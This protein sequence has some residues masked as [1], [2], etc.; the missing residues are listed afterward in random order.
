MQQ[1]RR[2]FIKSFTKAAKAKSILPWADEDSL[3]SSCT[4]CQKCI[5]ACPTG[6]LI[7]NTDTNYP[8]LDFHKSYCDFC[9]KC[10]DICPEDVFDIN[11]QPAIS[12]NINLKKS[13]CL[14]YNDVLCSSCRDA[15]DKNAIKP[16]RQLP[17]PTAPVIDDNCNKCG[18]CV[19]ICPQKAIVIT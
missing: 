19:D 7:S 1:S 6:V 5:E 10:A 18:A 17:Y 2:N 16:M 11:K 3:Q 14:A 13:K 12:A 15:C 8:T 4:K 9:Q